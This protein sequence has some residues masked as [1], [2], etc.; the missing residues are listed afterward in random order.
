MRLANTVAIVTGGGT[1]IDAAIARLLV[2]EGAQTTM[3]SK[4]ALIRRQ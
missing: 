4:H 3:R 1:G 2:Q